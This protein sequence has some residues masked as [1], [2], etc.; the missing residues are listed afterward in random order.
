VRIQLQLYDAPGELALG[1]YLFPVEH[2]DEFAAWFFGSLASFDTRLMT[3]VFGVRPPALEEQ[4]VVRITALG[5][6]DSPEQT[7]E[8]FRPLEDSPIK[9]L[10]VVHQEPAPT[11]LREVWGGVDLL[12]PKGIRYFA[13]T[14]WLKDPNDP[15]LIAG[16]KPA[17]ENLPKGGSHIMMNPWVPEERDDAALSGTTSLPFHLYGLGRNPS[18]DQMLQGWIDSSMRAVLPFSNGIGKINESD[19]MHRDQHVLAPANETRLEGLR[20]KLDPQ[21]RFHSFLRKED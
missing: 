11:T 12:Y 5:F 4:R 2:F 18:E 6:G 9:D 15:G 21:R 14:V 3:L 13:D 20:A 8:L 1:A 7:R 19:L 10:M 16:L 17:F